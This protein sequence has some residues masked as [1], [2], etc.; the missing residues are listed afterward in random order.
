MAAKQRADVRVTDKRMLPL[1]TGAAVSIAGSQPKGARFQITT[2]VD[3]GKPR[4]SRLGSKRAVRLQ[5]PRGRK[6]LRIVFLRTDAGKRASS[7]CLELADSQRNT[8]EVKGDD[9]SEEE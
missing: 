3:G 1:I 8:A 4:K 6:E 9:S 7:L 5:H 2:V